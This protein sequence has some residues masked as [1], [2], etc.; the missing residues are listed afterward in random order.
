MHQNLHHWTS[1]G[2]A[3]LH[4]LQNLVRVVVARLAGVMIHE[5]AEVRSIE[6]IVVGLVLYVEEEDA[7]EEHD[8]VA[9]L[10]L[11]AC[12]H[13]RKGSNGSTRHELVENPEH[14]KGSHEA[15]QVHNKRLL[16]RRLLSADE[17][18]TRSCHRPGR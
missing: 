8:C 10:D 13:K 9:Q 1:S 7:D 14:L 17:A 15:A 3:R 2:C 12:G 5:D 18:G 6:I 4:G 16:R 11:S